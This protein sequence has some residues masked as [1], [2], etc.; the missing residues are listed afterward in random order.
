MK[1]TLELFVPVAGTTLEDAVI[2][3]KA[4]KP[5]DCMEVGDGVDYNDSEIQVDGVH[6]S[7]R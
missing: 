4:L 1:V 6:V 2:S 7:Y 5:T 3:A